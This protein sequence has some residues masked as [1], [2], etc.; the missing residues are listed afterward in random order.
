M[1]IKIQNT[2]KFDTLRKERGY[3]VDKTGF[4]EK[5]L[6][7]PADASLFTRP[8][9][10]G[11]TL[12]MS[13]LASFFD[14]TRNSQDLFAG[15]KITENEKLCREWMNQ[16]PVIFLTFKEVEGFTFEDALDEI[17]TRMKN[18]YSDV[19]PML[20][21]KKLRTADRDILVLRF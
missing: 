13:M 18:L 21:R 9:R 14:I 4:L 5:F 20:D 8:R 2:E 3:Y 1:S 6:E 16:Y 19:E 12:L 10:F 17:R 15:L 11:K 7:S